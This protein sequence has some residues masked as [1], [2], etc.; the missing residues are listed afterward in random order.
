VRYDRHDRSAGVVSEC[1][2]TPTGY[3]VNRN[4]QPTVARRTDELVVRQFGDET[5]VY[6]LSTE[7]VTALDAATAAVWSAAEQPA[8]L[9]D[10]EASTG[11]SEEDVA[12]ALVKLDGADLLQESGVS[13]RLLLKRIGL[14]TAG[15]VALPVVTAAPAWAA[16]S[17][18]AQ[19]LTA[20]QTGCD[21][22]GSGSQIT[23]TLTLSGFADGAVSITSST[24]K[25]QS[26]NDATVATSV[27]V[28]TNTS[29]GTF[30]TTIT[31]K[32]SQ[33]IPSQTITVT[34]TQG[35]FTA[36]AT[37]VTLTPCG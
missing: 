3:R 1:R 37:G 13:R 35:S 20:R 10:I 16:C 6:D 9:S 30:I 15:V 8:T 12:A 34:A 25:N 29:C 21:G 36:S 33:T 32:I 5:V 19:A 17:G 11:Q 22:S 24:F 2:S 26:G 31:F 28:P 14:V 23:L 7:R 27:T 18:S 4:Q